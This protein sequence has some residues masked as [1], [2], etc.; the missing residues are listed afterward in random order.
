MLLFERGCGGETDNLWIRCGLRRAGCWEG[1]VMENPAV[2]QV[3]PV[4]PEVEVSAKARRR[5]YTAKEKKKILDEVAA[6]TQSGEIGALLRKKGIYSSSLFR[7]REARERGELD[8][9]SP[10][11]RGPVAKVP[12]PLAQENAELKR[13]LAKSEARLK[14]AEAIVE[15]QKK[16]SELLGI[17]LPPED[18][19]R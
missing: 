15:L 7:W 10:K 14:Q 2:V 16:I 1:R 8:A 13:A 3:A 5:R 12:N 18:T 11:K 9:L 17:Q 19:T 6:C 4:I